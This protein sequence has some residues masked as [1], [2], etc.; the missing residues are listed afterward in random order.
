MTEVS[1]ETKLLKKFASDLEDA[2][3]KKYVKSWLD[4]LAMADEGWPALAGSCP[5]AHD[6]VCETIG[7]AAGAI[8]EAITG[9][10]KALSIVVDKY[11]EMEEKNK[12]G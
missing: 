2:D 10:G 9:L 6:K 1:Y 12:T 7:D 5:S 3:V 11:V 4:D 8:D